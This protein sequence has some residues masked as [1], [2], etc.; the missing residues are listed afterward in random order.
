MDHARYAFERQLPASF[1]LGNAQRLP[2]AGDPLAVRFATGGQ[3]PDPR[4]LNQFAA[5]TAQTNIVESSVNPDPRDR[6]NC[7]AACDDNPERDEQR[8][9]TRKAGRA[10]RPRNLSDDE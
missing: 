6:H 1:M 4:R 8:P 10:L 3:L 9:R 7:K 2:V 5:G